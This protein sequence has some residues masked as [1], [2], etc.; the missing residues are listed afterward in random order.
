[1]PMTSRKRRRCHISAA[2]AALAFVGTSPIPSC[3]ALYVGEHILGS[4]AIPHQPEPAASEPSI[5][6][7]GGTLPERIVMRFESEQEDPF[8]PPTS[9][10]YRDSFYWLDRLDD[11][12]CAMAS[13]QW[14]AG[15]STGDR[16]TNT[17][18]F[19]LLSWNILAQSLYNSASYS[20][21]VRF[22]R[23]MEIIA[24]ASPSLVCLQEVDDH[25]SFLF[26]FLPAMHAL[27]YDGTAQGHSDVRDIK[28]R[29]GKNDRRHLTAT[30]W[31]ADHFRPVNVTDSNGVDYPHM[32][33]GRSLTCT[34]Q[35]ISGFDDTNS[36]DVASGPCL[37]VINC[38][39]EGH[40]RQYAARMTQ[41][42][43][44]MEDLS[45]R[46]T[47]GPDLNGLVIAGDF[48]CE[49]QSSVCSTYLRI[50]R[51]GRKGGLGGV[52]GTSAM[53]VPASLLES[54]EAAEALSPLLEWGKAIPN[55]DLENVKPHPFRRNSMVSAYPVLL[56]QRN[57]RLHFTYCANPD[58]PVA[59]L[60]QMWHSSFTLNRIGLR[61][62]FKSQKMRK[63]ILKTGLP[64]SRHPSD[65]LPIGAVFDWNACD[66]DA[67]MVD[68]NRQGCD[69]V[70]V[71]ELSIVLDSPVPIP[72]PKSPMMAFAELDMLMSTCPYDTEEQQDELMSIIDHVPDLPLDPKEK[73]SNSQLKKLH[74]M[75]NRKKFLLQNASNDVRPTLQ[76]I[77]KLSK[78]TAGMY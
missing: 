70:G 78:E 56:G 41:L 32:S 66:V 65:H 11:T 64:T 52:H 24:D 58:R 51:V 44:A 1:M 53:A 4:P 62:M 55:D 36:S 50:G 74:E 16:P 12:S 77:L 73:P 47:R 45:N 60:D 6:N 14:H 63:R 49:L 27:G 20:W 67:C 15:S 37:S 25:D 29:S 31:K 54:E 40:P 39:L 46:R 2:A 35:D 5:A 7:V 23:I 9:Q 10:N 59:G 28:R 38:H 19:S 26:D 21:E 72:K 61:R 34:L 69:E 57:P 8:A 75:R 76:R 18:P 71:N 68:S 22:K 43:H 33:R 17:Q 30:F 48:N 42:Q 13:D 3:H